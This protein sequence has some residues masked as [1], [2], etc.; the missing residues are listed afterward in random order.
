MKRL[1]MDEY[2]RMVGHRGVR[3][4]EGRETQDGHGNTLTPVRIERLGFRPLEAVV[5][6]PIPEGWDQAEA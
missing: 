2:E 6:V 4:S 5:V 3:V 1:T